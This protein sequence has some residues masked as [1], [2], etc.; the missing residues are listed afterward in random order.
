MVANV[1][2][3]VIGECR[4]AHKCECPEGA[5]SRLALPELAAP[6]VAEAGVSKPVETGWVRKARVGDESTR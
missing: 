5:G 3:P 2:A 4:F 6:K 1:R